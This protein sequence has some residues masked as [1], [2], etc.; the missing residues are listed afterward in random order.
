[1]IGRGGMAEVYQAF[2]EQLHREV[3]IKILQGD[4]CDMTSTEV[5]SRFKREC[6]IIAALDKSHFTR[7]YEFGSAPA[8]QPSSPQNSPFIVMELV[9]GCSLQS[10]LSA[11]K[12][13]NHKTALKMAL[14]LCDALSCAHDAGIV[15]RDLSPNNILLH[16][17]N[18]LEPKIIDFGLA[19]MKS[20]TL[21][22]T[23]YTMT[24]AL[25]GTPHYLSP[26]QCTGA[27]V[28]ARSDIYALGCILFESMTARK[29][30]ESETAIGVI[31]KHLNEA[32]MPAS[33]IVDVP[34]GIDALFERA[35]A[36]NRDDRYQSVQDLAGDI[37]LILS[38]RS[39]DLKISS[40]SVSRRNTS[41]WLRFA[42]FVLTASLIVFILQ[43]SLDDPGLAGKLLNL[44]NLLPQPPRV[45]LLN[46]CASLCQEFDK[47]S[48][49]LAAYRMIFVTSS[50]RATCP[51]P[52]VLLLLQHATT[53][54]ENSPT[55][56]SKALDS[57]VD[58]YLICLIQLLNYPL[59]GEHPIPDNELATHLKNI[60][61]LLA[62]RKLSGEFYLR[63][64]NEESRL[65]ALKVLAKTHQY[66]A[67]L[68][69]IDQILL[70][71]A[72]KVQHHSSQITLLLELADLCQ[73]AHQLELAT[74]YYARCD[75]LFRQHH[76]DIETEPQKRLFAG[77]WEIYY[78]TG[79]TYHALPAA[80]AALA[81]HAFGAAED[82]DCSRG[83]LFCGIGDYSKAIEVLRP[84][85]ISE[86]RSKLSP[87]HLELA[88]LLLA[89]AYLCAGNYAQSSHWLQNKVGLQADAIRSVLG[90]DCQSEQTR[91]RTISSWICS[92]RNSA[93][94]DFCAEELARTLFA[95]RHYAECRFLCNQL[96]SLSPEHS[97]WTPVVLLR[98]AQCYEATGDFQTAETFCTK[99]LQFNVQE[100]YSYEQWLLMTR[101]MLQQRKIFQAR[102]Y[103]KMA[104]TIPSTN[105]A[106]RDFL[107]VAA[108]KRTNTKAHHEE[109]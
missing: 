26:E 64:I 42:S 63:E 52:L 24:G 15:H 104:L 22:T 77:L 96:L 85:L 78:Q 2:D 102:C 58:Q 92:G 88:E 100:V 8:G 25:M 82:V 44:V 68:Q 43:D 90:M 27:A 56:E 107:A 41:H 93:N 39:A 57:F 30:F 74:A 6:K 62:G 19:L 13:M 46:I 73:N 71:H 103:A 65:S 12:P 37:Q 61:L 99:S 17:S 70:S 80:K 3:A 23:S 35:L 47:P 38:G 89:R 1:M 79:R 14:I 101:I 33:K 32:P 49:Q 105:H 48:A 91:K 75:Q 40:R 7:I 16:D 50:A 83:A 87:Q 21:L 106:E 31:Y 51:G 45:Y 97:P 66:N 29:V 5:L 72:E 9:K 34:A 53:L 4:R 67:S 60:D 108:S 55:R 81:A 28:D 84:L 109:P 94:F 54:M 11:N 76:S 98:L 20:A 10:W 59:S 18:P 69:A 95:V 36:K 86:K